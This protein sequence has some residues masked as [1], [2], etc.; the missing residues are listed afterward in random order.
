MLIRVDPYTDKL[1]PLQV[2]PRQ[3]RAKSLHPREVNTSD[4]C[5]KQLCPGVSVSWE[6]ALPSVY[7]DSFQAGEFYSIFWPG[8]QIPLWD[9]GTLAD[10][11]NRK[12]DLKSPKVVLPGGPQQALAIA[13]EESDIDDVGPLPPS[14]EPILPPARMSG[15]PV[16]SLSVGGPATLSV[17]NR[18]SAGRL[19]YP[20]TATLSYDTAP[21]AF[22]G[23]RLHF[24]LSNSKMTIAARTD[25]GSTFEKRTRTS[26]VHMSLGAYLRTTSTDFLLTLR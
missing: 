13:A 21:D 20:V 5:F 19:R 12:L 18:T 11:S 25:S 6:V 2:D 4:P 7:F 15:A 14:P 17:K 1:Q 24:I 16:F 23:N 26:G 3:L 22:D 10:H 9:W 8:G